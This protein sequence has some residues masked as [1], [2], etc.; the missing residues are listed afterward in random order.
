MARATTFLFLI[1]CT[2]P[3][4][5]FAKATSSSKIGISVVVK[6]TPKCDFHISTTESSASYSQL[7]SSCQITIDKIQ[8]QL[9]KINY[10]Q[11]PH[12]KNNDFARIV[13]V[14]Q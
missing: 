6:E 4:Y 14:V 3:Q 1:A 11:Q 2:F 12:T 13:L 10:L 8:K 9:T 5:A 7:S